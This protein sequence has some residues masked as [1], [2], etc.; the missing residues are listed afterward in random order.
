M[1]TEQQTLAELLDGPPPAAAQ[2]APVRRPIFE[3]S[4][5]LSCPLCQDRDSVT[6]AAGN[7]V[8]CPWCGAKRPYKRPGPLPL[9][10]VNNAGKGVHH[11]R[12]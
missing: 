9:V 3:H 11:G 1:K 6:N 2:A 5:P 4:R 8:Q 10:A 12:R 7:L